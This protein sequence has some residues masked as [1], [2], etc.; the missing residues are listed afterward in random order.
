[1]RKGQTGQ[2]VADSS[3]N[4]TTTGFPTQKDLIEQGKALWHNGASDRLKLGEIFSNLRA[5]QDAYKK[6]KDGL[7]YSQAVA[8]T[9]TPWSTAERYREMYEVARDNGIPAD[10]FLA[11]ADNGCNLA[12]DRETT[13][14]GILSDIPDL[15]KLDVTNEKAVDAVAQRIRQDYPLSAKGEKEK[16]STTPVE[17]LTARQA[18]R[19]QQRGRSCNPSCTESL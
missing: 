15:P 18:T 10:V 19:T 9:G 6:G 2:I 1:M 13:V 12:K 14:A 7:S 16:E 8:K 4:E 3:G 11:L 17:M 5:N